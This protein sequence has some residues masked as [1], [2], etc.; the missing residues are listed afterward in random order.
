[1]NSNR[2]R[3]WAL[4]GLIVG[5]VYV[6]DR[7]ASLKQSE[8]R[9]VAAKAE[10]NELQSKLADLSRLQAAPQI[11]ALKADAPD[12]IINRI[13]AAGRAANLS[14]ESLISQTPQQPKRIGR[15]DFQQRLTTVKL[16]GV[17]LVKLAAFCDA[18]ADRSTG[19][20][21][22]DLI[23]RT[24]D[25]PATARS[26]ATGGPV[27]LWDAELTLTQTIFSPKSEG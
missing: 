23:L 9:L 4:I 16:A 18:A 24:P 6:A 15:T 12:E 1:M 26:D 8:S 5:V 17:S 3:I 14:N 10:L 25:G 21:V 27:E 22:R 7:F 20:V 11:A 19:T 2:M 13:E